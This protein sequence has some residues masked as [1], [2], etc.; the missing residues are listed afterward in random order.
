MTAEINDHERENYDKETCR[1]CLAAA[2]SHLQKVF[3]TAQV[4]VK[5][6]AG[7]VRESM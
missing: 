4:R 6:L 2:C 3:T 1:N 7:D 5:D